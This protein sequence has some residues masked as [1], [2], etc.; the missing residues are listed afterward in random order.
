[1][2]DAGT[3]AKTTMQ[4]NYTHFSPDDSDNCNGDSDSAYSAYEDLVVFLAKND[5]PDL[6]AYLSQRGP[7][8]LPRRRKHQLRSVKFPADLKADL[9]P[10][11]LRAF[12]DLQIDTQLRICS[13]FGKKPDKNVEL[14]AN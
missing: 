3:K 6:Q 12:N 13:L 10:E 11:F 1:M 5:S 9:T 4:S 14:I 7:G 2:L 8:K